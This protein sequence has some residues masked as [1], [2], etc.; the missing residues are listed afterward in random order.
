MQKFL[1]IKLIS[2]EDMTTKDG[3]TED[4]TFLLEGEKT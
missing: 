2:P 4:E 1:R 3:I